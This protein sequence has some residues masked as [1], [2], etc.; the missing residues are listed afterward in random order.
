MKQQR[1]N[2]VTYLV[3]AMQSRSGAPLGGLPY[4]FS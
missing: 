2:R 1:C 3:I 4:D